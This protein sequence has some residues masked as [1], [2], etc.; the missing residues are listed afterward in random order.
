MVEEKNKA[1]N[2]LQTKMTKY[3]FDEV[4]CKSKKM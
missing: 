4:Q 2:F 1:K 3:D